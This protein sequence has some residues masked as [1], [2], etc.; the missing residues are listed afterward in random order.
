MKWKSGIKRAWEKAKEKRFHPIS[1]TGTKIQRLRDRDR[2]TSP[3]THCRCQRKSI[4]AADSWQI[5]CFSLSATATAEQKGANG[6]RKVIEWKESES[7]K[8]RITTAK[9][10]C[11]QLFCRWRL[12]E[13][14]CGSCSS[15]CT[16]TTITTTTIS[17]NWLAIWGGKLAHHF[18][19][20]NLSGATLSRRHS[21][22]VQLVKP[23]TTRSNKK[24]YSDSVVTVLLWKLCC[25]FLINSHEIVLFRLIDK[26]TL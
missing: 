11:E 19:V 1:I 10:E 6:K 25:L 9:K 13:N 12:C 20:I 23:S 7:E 4:P 5:V 22:A 15:K 8:E 2:D 14:C 16:A 18:W 17:S 21:L 3:H 26:L 24:N